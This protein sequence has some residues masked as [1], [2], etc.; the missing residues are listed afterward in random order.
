MKTTDFFARNGAA[1]GLGAA[2]YLVEAFEKPVGSII[3]PINMGSQ[4]VVAKIADKQM[5]DMSKLPAERDAIVLAL[6]GKKTAE[7]Q[8]LLR[9]SIL[10][11]LIQQGKVKMHRD[12]I[13]R[14]IARYRS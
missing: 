14:L 5:P 3:G 6:K 8:V 2:S 4:T 11:T 1:E 10:S 13:N 7:R 9:D 12:V